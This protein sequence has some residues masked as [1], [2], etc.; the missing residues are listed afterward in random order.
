MP[1]QLTIS[2]APFKSSH[3]A[4][5]PTPFSPLLPISPPPHMQKFSKPTNDNSKLK[6]TAQLQPPPPE[7]LHWLWQC[8]RCNRVYQLGV[9][10]RCL[11]DGHLFCAGTTVVKRSKR[12]GYKKTLRH[13]ACAS[14]FDYQGWKAWG[15]WRRQLQEQA[16]AAD[17]LMNAE[18]ALMEAFNVPAVPDEGRWFSGVWSRKP[19]ATTSTSYLTSPELMMG[20]F[21]EKPKKE[22]W[23]K[24]DYPSECRWGKQF[25]VQD[26]PSPSSTS[27][28]TRSRTTSTTVPSSPPPTT[29]PAASDN[30]ENVP[31]TT[32]AIP[33]ATTKGSGNSN[34]TFDDILLTISD[35]HSSDYLEPLVPAKPAKSTKSLTPTEEKTTLPSMTD[36]LESSKRRKRK[37]MSGIPLVPSP[38]G[39]NP[40]EEER[41]SLSRSGSETGKEK[42]LK[43]KT[44]EG[45]LGRA[46]DDLEVEVRKGLGIRERAEGVVEGLRYVRGRLGSGSL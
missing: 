9:T 21:W 26:D 28:S 24:C 10:R 35:P 15:K 45:A 3:L 40:V 31:T 41:P 30:K 11:D 6:A 44:S 5:P 34:T 20:R 14:E 36:L 29:S 23:G 39:A 37:S 13:Q 42:G 38:L 2:P 22:C 8:H 16:D 18:A 43:K 46:A 27:T 33:E 17:A 25:G 7:P 12:N 1:R 32:L 4:I 19:T